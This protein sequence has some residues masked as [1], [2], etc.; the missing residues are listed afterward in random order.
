VT[1]LRETGFL[2]VMTEISNDSWDLVERR[3]GRGGVTVVLLPTVLRGNGCALP[4][5]SALE[6]TFAIAGTKIGGRWVP[7]IVTSSLLLLVAKKIQPDTCLRHFCR[8]R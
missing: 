5:T 4:A 1:E 3:E 2:H 6:C 7:H 8:A